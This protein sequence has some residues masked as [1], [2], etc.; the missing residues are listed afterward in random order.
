MNQIEILDTNW[1]LNVDLENDLIIDWNKIAHK[2]SGVL[3][4][5]SIYNYELK[6]PVNFSSIPSVFGVEQ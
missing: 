4:Y 3:L 1:H 6:L 2:E 5:M